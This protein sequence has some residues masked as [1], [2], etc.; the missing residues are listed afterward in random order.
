[1]NTT[2]PELSDEQITS[3]RSNI[4]TNVDRA[5]RA[6][7]S[8]Y[9][10][11]VLGAAAVIVI[12]SVGTTAIQAMNPVGGGADSMSKS[13]LGN[14]E[15]DSSRAEGASGDSAGSAAPDEATPDSGLVKGAAPEDADREIV[16]TGSIGM[17][18][19]KPVDTAARISTYVSSAGGRVDSRSEQAS[20]EDDGGAVRLVVRVPQDKVEDSIATFRTYGTVDYVTVEDYDATAEGKDLDARIK[21]L[22]ISVARLSAL[23][24]KATSTNELIKAESALTQRQAEL[25]SLVSQRKG[26]TDRVTLSSLEIQLA[27]KDAATSPSASGFWGGVVDGWNALV[28]VFEDF[29]HGFGVILPWLLVL[30]LIGGLFWLVVRGRRSV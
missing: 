5:A 25:D 15:P 20:K 14:S 12:G 17:T 16:T 27:A 2:I 13:D 10:K 22:G 29:V 4:M 3:M 18:V 7:T 19:T 26:L 6:K 1:M 24:D 11:V 23:M 28:S 9:R 21:A 30:G 8:R